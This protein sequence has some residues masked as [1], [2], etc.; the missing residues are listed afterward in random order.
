MLTPGCTHAMV[1]FV[2]PFKTVKAFEV[3]LMLEVLEV[4]PELRSLIREALNNLTCACP[5]CTLPV[6]VEVDE[7][8]LPF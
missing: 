2:D 6:G 8:E 4:P 3:V 1:C 7:D 5:A